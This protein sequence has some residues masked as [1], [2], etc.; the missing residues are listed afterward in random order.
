VLTSSSG[1]NI[2]IKSADGLYLRTNGDTDALTINSSQD[3]TFAATVRATGVFYGND[4]GASNPGY[5]FY[6]AASGMYH[7]GSDN[8]GFAVSG[9]NVATLTASSATFGGTVTS[10]GATVSSGSS[11]TTSTISAD[12]NAYLNITATDVNNNGLAKITLSAG[13]AADSSSYS[14]IQYQ[15]PNYSQTAGNRLLFQRGSGATVLTLDGSGNASFSGKVSMGDQPTT[16]NTANSGGAYIAGGNSAGNFTT[17]ICEIKN[18]GSGMD[19]STLVVDSTI[20]DTHSDRGPFQVHMTGRSLHFIKTTNNGYIFRTGG[21]SSSWD[22]SSDI[23]IKENI[24]NLKGKS[25]SIINN[26]NLRPVEFD[27]TQDFI[28]N[29]GI[30]ENEHHNYGGFIANEIKEI[31]PSTV[32]EMTHVVDGESVN[33]FL[34]LDPSCLLAIAIGAIQE[35]SDKVEALENA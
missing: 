20:D 29:N 31:L 1:E 22:T 25:L 7:A 12:R 24:T 10:T 30:K 17:G 2:L 28:T 9:N 15:N 27:Y 23:R 8:I 5:R 34:S 35:L 18:V 16:F 19:G 6:N 21:S 13:N 14:A 33:D 4:N 3:A 32:T 26:N 11:S